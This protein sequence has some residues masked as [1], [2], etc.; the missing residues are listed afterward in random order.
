MTFCPSCD[1]KEYQKAP[2]NDACRVRCRALKELAK[3][4]ENVARDAAKFSSGVVDGV[5][6][7]ARPGRAWIDD[8]GKTRGTL[9]FYYPTD[10]SPVVR[11]VSMFY[12]HGGSFGYGDGVE[13]G[14]QYLCSKL[15]ALT[16][17][18]LF[19]PD[20]M[21]T[22]SN[23][24]S[25]SRHYSKEIIQYLKETLISVVAPQQEVVLVGDSSGANQA[26]SLLFT[27]LREKSRRVRAVVLYSP[28]LDLTCSSS[29]YLSNQFDPA[30]LNGD[31]S[32]RDPAGDTQSG[33]RA[34]AAS[35]L[36][37]DV[38][39]TDPNYSPAWFWRDEELVKSWKSANVPLCLF[40]GDQ[41]TLV[42][43]CLEFTMRLLDRD[44]PIQS[45][46]VNG[47]WH[48]WLHYD[49]AWKGRL[50]AFENTRNFLHDVLT[51]APLKTGVRYWQEA[52]EMRQN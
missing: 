50:E 8:N 19:C 38:A 39:L 49:T 32:F 29:T 23:E 10:A 4:L 17:L 43:E 11:N 45:W 37:S 1:S 41:E 42:G 27:L 28:W 7:E 35:Y 2:S 52:M 5:E 3:A 51:G 18:S 15:V 13:D 24:S 14:V 26:L 6:H 46:L 20:H 36:G 31:V 34:T 30:G 22:G 40:I 48:T 25:S 33:F 44:I 47:G 9:H 16:K 12:V 21:L